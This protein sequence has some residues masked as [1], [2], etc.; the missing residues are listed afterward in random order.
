MLVLADRIAVF[1]DYVYKYNAC[2]QRMV[3]ECKKRNIDILLI[4]LPFPA[5]E[6][7]QMDAN[8]V[9]EIADE[10]GLNYL[11]FSPQSFR[12]L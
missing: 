2:V 1:V 8:R 3:Q 11:N 10:Y 4:C 9:Y 12:G 5:D 7:H 6:G